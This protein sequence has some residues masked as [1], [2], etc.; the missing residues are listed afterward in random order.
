M[1]RVRVNGVG[2]RKR[3]DL[4]QKVELKA[5]GGQEGTGKRDDPPPPP[6]VQSRP[7]VVPEG[8][9]GH[10]KQMHRGGGEARRKNHQS[11]AEEANGCIV[12]ETTCAGAAIFEFDSIGSHCIQY[13]A[14]NFAPP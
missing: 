5:G 1:W 13:A 2:E 11:S 10:N 8:E 12:Y 3:R 6:R 7:V 9:G 4:S 14:H